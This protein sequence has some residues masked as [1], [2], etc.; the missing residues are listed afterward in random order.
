MTTAEL[1]VD[2]A[3]LRALHPQLCNSFGERFAEVLQ[4]RANNLEPW[5]KWYAAAD[6]TVWKTAAHEAGHTLAAYLRADTLQL[7]SAIPGNGST[8]RTLYLRR[9]ADVEENII[10]TLAGPMAEY[11]L[12]GSPLVLSMGEGGDGT[13]IVELL[14]EHDP[15]FTYQ[16]GMARSPLYLRAVPRAREFVEKFK[17]PISL[18]AVMI[19]EFGILSGSLIDQVFSTVEVDHA[20]H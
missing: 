19:A 20:D 3:D 15:T 1:N 10:G 13:K 18:L 14:A 2:A 4:S 7:A 12:A 6:A 9:S 16:G 8:G 5:T 17:R 11:L